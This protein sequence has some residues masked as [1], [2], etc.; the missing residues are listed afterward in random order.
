MKTKRD[1]S[2]ATE[3]ATRRVWR[4]DELAA[5]LA[6]HLRG[7]DRLVWENMQLGAVHSPRPDVYTVP[8]VYSRFT[9]LAYEVKV[10]VSDFRRDVT[11]GKWQSYLKFAAGVIFA[12][13]VGLISK[14]DL[15]PGCGLILRH[16]GCWRT[17]KGPTLGAIE[18]LPRDA[19]MKLLLDGADRA[20][21]RTR[22][23]DRDTWGLTQRAFA[24]LGDEIGGLLRD[25]ERAATNLRQQR[26][27]IEARIAGLDEQFA[28]AKRKAMAGVAEVAAAQ[29]ALAEAL[30]LKPDAPIYRIVQVARQ[31]AADL[32]VDPR[33]EQLRAEVRHMRQALDRADAQILTVRGLDGGEVAA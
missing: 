1:P 11:A 4:H 31:R 23:R 7:G 22:A 25:R 6:E 8:K 14:A 17:V 29:A 10:S 5:D 26:A 12:A 16:D 3:A 19:W 21:A 28:E 24:A 33:I 13:P 18:T 32:Q 27:I 20:A 2:G 9:P 30:G 15:P